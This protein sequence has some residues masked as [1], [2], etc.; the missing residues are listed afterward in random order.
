MGSKNRSTLRPHP[1]AERRRWLTRH[2]SEILLAAALFMAVEAT[3]AASMQK[4]RLGLH[5]WP[6]SI[7]M[8]PVIVCTTIIWTYMAHDRFTFRGRAWSNPS[9]VKNLPAYT[10]LSLLFLIL[11]SVTSNLARLPF[12][13]IIAALA[14]LG[15]VKFSIVGRLIWRRP[16]GGRA[17]PIYEGI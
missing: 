9:F 14:I 16:T 6:F 12:G 10:A 5:N 2:L 11:Q 8:G 17:L 15:F 13:T 4:M 3:A 7:V 1:A